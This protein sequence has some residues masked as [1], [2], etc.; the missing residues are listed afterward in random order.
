MGRWGD[1]VM[2][3]GVMGRWGVSIL[4]E[5]SDVPFASSNLYKSDFGITTNH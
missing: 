4:T 5:G 1:G 3:D 2:G